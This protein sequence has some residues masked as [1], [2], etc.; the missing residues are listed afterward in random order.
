MGIFNFPLLKSRHKKHSAVRQDGGP[1]HH[2]NFLCLVFGHKYYDDDL[3]KDAREFMRNY[4]IKGK[5]ERCDTLFE[6]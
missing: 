1:I 5:C 3:S 4:N 2:G 6:V